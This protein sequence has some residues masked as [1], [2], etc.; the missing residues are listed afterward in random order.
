MPTAIAVLTDLIFRMR[1]ES[2]AQALG[3]E[4]TSV[5]T[6]DA[7]HK[8]LE[9]GPVDLVLVDM[10]LPTD[11]AGD[12][13]R[14][15]KSHHEDPRV[16]AFVSHVEANLAEAARRAG[17]DEVLARSAFSTKLPQILAPGR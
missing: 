3:R 8:A 16:V 17:A 2:T 4:I 14:T 6:V 1:I 10:N 11:T 9:E 15:A 13:I 12:A 7:L 5:S